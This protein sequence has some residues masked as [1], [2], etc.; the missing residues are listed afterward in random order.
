MDLSMYNGVK[1]TWSEKNLRYCFIAGL[2]DAKKTTKMVR[3]S[4]HVAET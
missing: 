4:S 3:I 2:K 1:R